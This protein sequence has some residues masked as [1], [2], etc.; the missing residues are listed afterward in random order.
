MEEGK[1]CVKSCM[2]LGWERVR[3]TLLMQWR[4]AAKG[5]HLFTARQTQS[6]L[7]TML[8]YC[9]TGA[10]PTQMIP[11]HPFDSKFPSSLMSSLNQRPS[12]GGRTPTFTT[13]MPAESCLACDSLLATSSCFGWHN[14]AWEQVG[15]YLGPVSHCVLGT[16]CTSVSASCCTSSS[17]PICETYLLA[18]GADNSI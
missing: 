15:C 12:A 5:R 14:M 6:T 9:S 11:A 3:Y 17:Q 8:P 16:T 4:G 7:R 18:R 2:Y 13:F 1:R 10:G